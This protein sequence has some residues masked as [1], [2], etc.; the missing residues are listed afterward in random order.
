MGNKIIVVNGM[1]GSGK[2]TL[3]KA[4]ESS[5]ASYRY[6]HEI[7]KELR[8]EVSF[9]TTT[10]D[11]DFDRRILLM[12][13]E[14]DLTIMQTDKTAIVETWHT[15]NTAFALARG[16]PLASEFLDNLGNKL[17]IFDVMHVLIEVSWDTFRKRAAP[18]EPESFFRR[19]ME[20]LEM[21]YERYSIEPIRVGNDGNISDSFNSLL[22]RIRK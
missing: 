11:A 20:N 18:T 8:K 4:L 12:E 5:D 9:T 7:G 22:Q 10:N 13:N 16:S 17:T 3:S 14:R 15:G 1:S 21:L 19:L 6:F 2:T